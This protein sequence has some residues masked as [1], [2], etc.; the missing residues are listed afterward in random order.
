VIE[1]N[2][3]GFLLKEKASDVSIKEIINY[4]EGKL[5]VSDNVTDIIL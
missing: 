4:T 2:N 1:V 3:E 5:I